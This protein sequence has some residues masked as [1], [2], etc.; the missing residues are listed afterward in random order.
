MASPLSGSASDLIPLLSP[1][2]IA[3]A[4]FICGRLETISGK[5]TD[6]SY[7]IDTTYLARLR[8]A[9]RLRHA[10]RRLSPSQEHDEHNAH[11]RHRRRRRRSLLLPL[12]LRLRLPLQGLHRKTF[13]RHE[14][15]LPKAFLRLP[16]LSLPVDVLHRR[17]GDH[18]RVH[19]RE[20]AVRRIFDLFFFLNR[21]G[22]LYRIGSGL[23]TVGRLP[24]RTENREL[25]LRSRVIDFA[26][27]GAWSAVGRTAVTTT[28]A[29][30]TAALTTVKL[31]SDETKKACWLVTALPEG[32]K[33]QE[34]KGTKA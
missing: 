28:L 9:A 6:A 10:L 33:E 34:T 27:S 3:A 23:P 8:D 1:V 15:R 20:D 16:V 30:C 19:R 31:V 26:G 5:F 21:F 13:L 32:L 2:A 11:E 29:G 18:Q 24:P 14:R 22:L 17:R 4:E 7:A 25:L 12:R